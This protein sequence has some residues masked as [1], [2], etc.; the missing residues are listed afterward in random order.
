MAKFFVD[1]SKEGAVDSTVQLEDGTSVT[2]TNDV[3]VLFD[4]SLPKADILLAINRAKD[5]INELLD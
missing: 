2:L 4:D 5:R 3:R 1:V